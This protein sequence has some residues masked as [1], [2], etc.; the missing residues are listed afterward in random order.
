MPKVTEARLL[1]DEKSVPIN[2]GGDVLTARYA[3]RALAALLGFSTADATLI[4]TAI[5]ELARNIVQH[6]KLGEIV[7]GVIEEGDT[8]GIAVV[9]RDEG[10]GIPDLRATMVGGYSTSGGLGL[11]LS[12]VRRLMDEVEIDSEVGR[13]TIVTARKWNSEKARGRG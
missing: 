8:V 13:G 4:A 12:G 2:S 10:P 7:L 3:G 9:A 6:A 11:G 1:R 5:S